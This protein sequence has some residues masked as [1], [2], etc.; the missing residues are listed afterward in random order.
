MPR[1]LVASRREDPDFAEARFRLALLETLGGDREA[2]RRALAQA[3]AASPAL[4]AR[5]KA[6]SRVAA[7]L[8]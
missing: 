6:D 3:I 4:R 5:A 7:L 8:P 2:A 1:G